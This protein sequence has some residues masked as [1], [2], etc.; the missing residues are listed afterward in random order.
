MGKPNIADLRRSYRK[1]G[2][3]EGDLPDEPVKLFKEWLDQAIDTEDTEANVMSLATV[4]ENGRPDVRIL[5]LKGVENGGILFF[6]NYRSRKA[7]NLSKNP[8]ASCCFWWPGLERQ[9]RLSGPVE[10]VSREVSEE[11]FASRPRESQIGAWTSEQSQSI[12]NRK[13]LEEEFKKYEDKFAGGEVP[14][15]EFWGGYRLKPERVEFWQGRAGRLHD[16][17]LYTSEDHDKWDRV[18]LAP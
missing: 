14:M 9:V 8:F 10:K 7:R 12:E 1:G 3:D 11:Y 6:T 17:I 13:I 5:L 16:R 2:L 4:D 15:P 18:R